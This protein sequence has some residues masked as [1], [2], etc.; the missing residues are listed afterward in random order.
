MLAL[1]PLTEI[2]QPPNTSSQRVIIGADGSAVAEGAQV[3]R[4]IE[5]ERR[6]VTQRARPTTAVRSA[7]G[8][9]AVLEH[10]QSPR[11]GDGVERIH[12]ACLAVQVDGKN[13]RRAL[14]DRRTDGLRIDQTRPLV[15]VAEHRSGPGVRDRERRS[16][17][18][19]PRN[20]HLVSRPDAVA[21][22][23]EL[24]GR[25]SRCDADA[26]R[27]AAVR[28]EL[29]FELL[30]L[31]PERERARLEESREGPR[32]LAL[33]A[34]ML[35]LERDEPH[36]ITVQLSCCC[37]CFQRI[38]PVVIRYETPSYASPRAAPE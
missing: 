32:E 37:Q 8:L 14:G 16:D 31:L 20:D 19:M 2:A 21:S 27:H 4:R 6:R 36:R 30:D 38:A 29:G 12:V 23:H 15:D 24:E 33:D 11:P 18:R 10:E 35:A 17:E 25:G 5:R 9:C 28:R 26:M 13:R 3:L 1:C 34:P 7:V 22:E